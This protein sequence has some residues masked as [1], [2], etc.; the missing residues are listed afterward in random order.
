MKWVNEREDRA[1]GVGQ[2]R[3]FAHWGHGQGFSAQT[4]F[5]S[6][7][8]LQHYPHS[9][10]PQRGSSPA[11]GAVGRAAGWEAIGKLD[12]S[13]GA[14]WTHL[15]GSAPSKPFIQT[16]WSF[17]LFCFATITLSGRVLEIVSTASQQLLCRISH[18]PAGWGFG[19]VFAS[20]SD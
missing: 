16:T 7:F 18:F 4:S 1:F 13:D 10:V 17:L 15:W 8:L 3:V 9:L 14:T 6:G 2:R 19:E 20:F 11:H 5:F 12:S